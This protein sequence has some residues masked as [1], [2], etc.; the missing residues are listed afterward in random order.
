MRYASGCSGGDDAH[1][2]SVACVYRPHRAGVDYIAFFRFSDLL[3][4]STCE[5]LLEVQG[6]D[7]GVH[8]PFWGYSLIK[9][10]LTNGQMKGTGVGVCAIP[11]AVLSMRALM[12]TRAFLL[13]SWAR[14]AP[15]IL[16]V[17]AVRLPRCFFWQMVDRTCLYC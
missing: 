7:R 3:E 16:L 6:V 4:I 8:E 2:G 13:F 11:S 9:A 17:D 10:F 15:S 12:M 14:Y 1:T 5:F